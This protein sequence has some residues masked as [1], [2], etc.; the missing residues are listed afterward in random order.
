MPDSG[1]HAPNESIRLDAFDYARR[2]YCALL[3]E[4]AR[5]YGGSQV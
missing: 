4:L 1:A 3:P 2:G 5:T